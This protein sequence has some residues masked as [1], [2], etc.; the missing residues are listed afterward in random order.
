MKTPLL[1]WPA[2]TA[3]SPDEPLPPLWSRLLWMA[4]IWLASIAVLTAVAMVLR[5]VLKP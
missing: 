1:R 2:I 5:W 4:G 3:A